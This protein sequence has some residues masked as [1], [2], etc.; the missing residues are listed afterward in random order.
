MC[1]TNTLQRFTC[2]RLSRQRQGAMAVFLNT[3][4]LMKSWCIAEQ[5]HGMST[6][7]PTL[8]MWMN[9]ASSVQQQNSLLPWTTFKIGSSEGLKLEMHWL[10]D[11]STFYVLAAGRNIQANTNPDRSVDCTKRK[12]SCLAW[13]INFISGRLRQTALTAVFAK[14]NI[15]MLLQSNDFRDRCP[16]LGNQTPDTTQS[17]V[18]LAHCV[19]PWTLGH[20][21]STTVPGA[22]HPHTS[23]NL[24]PDKS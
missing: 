12:A 13:L 20:C 11:V 19:H 9:V 6:P 14:G 8:Y 5:T 15:W 24:Q 16:V 7:T 3:T 1:W 22:S 21:A 18:L 23:T 10:T 2:S 17:Y 4:Y